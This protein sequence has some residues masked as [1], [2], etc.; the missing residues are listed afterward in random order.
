MT[1]L[2]E[3]VENLNTAAEFVKWTFQSTI[4]EIEGIIES[5]KKAKH[6]AIAKKIE[7][8]LDSKNEFKKFLSTQ[9]HASAE[10]FEYPLGIYVQSGN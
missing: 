4:S 5:N 7:S 10:F 3:E 1:K 8:V 9:P 6:E 2:K